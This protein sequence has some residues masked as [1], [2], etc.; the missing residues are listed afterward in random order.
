MPVGQLHPEL[1]VGQA[2]YDGAFNFDDIFLRQA[3]FLPRSHRGIP[4]GTSAAFYWWLR[5]KGPA[6][7]WFSGCVSHSCA[8]AFPA[9]APCRRQ[10]RHASF[11]PRRPH[12]T[13]RRHAL[14]STRP[15]CPSGS[16]FPAPPIQAVS[17]SPARFR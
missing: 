6:Q 8:L 10:A 14:Q 13:A 3:R 12:R 15:R 5:W 1:R 11:P 16:A 7:H 2:L 9:A 4:A 17:G